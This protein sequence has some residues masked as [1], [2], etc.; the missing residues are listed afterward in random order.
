M[1]YDEGLCIITNHKHMHLYIIMCRKKT[2]VMIFINIS[3]IKYSMNGLTLAT[4]FHTFKTFF[5]IWQSV[6]Q[7]ILNIIY[8]PRGKCLIKM[9]YYQPHITHCTDYIQCF[10]CHI[11]KCNHLYIHNCRLIHIS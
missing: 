7:T 10:P 1:K 6:Y 5:H 11:Q 8:H 3:C 2:H 9:L 4:S